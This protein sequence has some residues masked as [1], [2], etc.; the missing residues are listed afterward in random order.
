MH[1]CFRSGLTSPRIVQE[2]RD[3]A[4]I[5]SLVAAGLGVGWVLGTARWRCPKSVVIMPV[6]DL[7]LPLPL[8]LA[9]RKD[10]SSPLLASFVGEVQRLP[11]VRALK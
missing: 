1:A 6:V 8:S 11:A 9:W 4:T 5:L 7:N 10:N 2:G 3:E